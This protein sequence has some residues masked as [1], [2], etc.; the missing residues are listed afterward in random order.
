MTSKAIASLDE[1]LIRAEEVLVEQREYSLSPSSVEASEDVTHEWTVSLA[2][3]ALGLSDLLDRLC[4]RPGRWIVVAEDAERSHRFWQALAFEDGSLIVE[5]SSGIGCTDAER[6]APEVEARLGDLGW[7]TPDPPKSPNWRRVEA[8]FSPDTADVA[9]QAIE[10]MRNVFGLDETDRV[11]LTLFPSARR[12]DTPASECL[13]EDGPDLDQA[14]SR[15]G[16]QPSDEAWADYY[17]QLFPGFVSPRNSFEVWKYATTATTIAEHY[18]DARAVALFR[19][20]AAY[21]DQ[22][23]WPI[24][25]PPVV[26][27]NLDIDKAACLGCS[28]IAGTDGDDLMAI[29]L[30]HAVEH[31]AA[32]EVVQ[33]HCGLDDRRPISG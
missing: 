22:K 29:G 27:S 14:A 18:W 9:T 23:S 20:E 15:R 5:A 4:S 21:G 7:D 3:F 24:S 33:L 2:T 31:G 16:F 13:S 25:H 1:W 19:W 11:H 30:A 6:L 26:V 28:W 8:T 32:A 12:G 10:T 17:R